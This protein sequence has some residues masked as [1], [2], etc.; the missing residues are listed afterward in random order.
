MKANVFRRLTYVGFDIH[1]LSIDT[2][3]KETR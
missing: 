2:A 3:R 1:Q